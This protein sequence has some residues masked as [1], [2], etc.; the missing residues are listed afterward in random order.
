MTAPPIVLTA[1]FA[2]LPLVILVAKRASTRVFAIGALLFSLVC[3]ANWIHVNPA[4]LNLSN[5]LW[6]APGNVSDF[7][8]RLQVRAVFSGI[9]YASS[10]VLETFGLFSRDLQELLIVPGGPLKRTH[11]EFLLWLGFNLSWIA[12]GTLAILKKWAAIRWPEK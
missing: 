6:F 3:V 4:N 11:V 9:Y 12:G 2:I 7:L 8:E 5:N 1:Y 10:G